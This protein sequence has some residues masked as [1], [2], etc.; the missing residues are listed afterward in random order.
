[1]HFLSLPTNVNQILATVKLTLTNEMDELWRPR[2]TKSQLSVSQRYVLE[3]VEKLG[4]AR[5]HID[6][7]GGTSRLVEA[8]T[9]TRQRRFQRA[10][11]PRKPKLKPEFLG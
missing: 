5:P 6:S 8:A 2:R 9:K 1:M 4:R 10:C 7:D 3:E 11:G